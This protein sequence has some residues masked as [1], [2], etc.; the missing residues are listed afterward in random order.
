MVAIRGRYGDEMI[1]ARR[2]ASATLRPYFKAGEDGRFYSLIDYRDFVLE[3]DF[4]QVAH[5]LWTLLLAYLGGHISLAIYRRRPTGEEARA[6]ER[7]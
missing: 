6:D 4:I 7:G 2:G 1:N 5:G 3:E